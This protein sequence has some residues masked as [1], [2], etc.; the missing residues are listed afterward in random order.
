MSTDGLTIK[1]RIALLKQSSPSPNNKNEISPANV[2]PKSTGFALQT[3][4]IEERSKSVSY[5]DTDAI[6]GRVVALKL[7]S[8]PVSSSENQGDKSSGKK[9]IADRI[10]ALQHKPL[11]DSNQS[12][13]VPKKLSVNFN[14]EIISNDV[15]GNESNLPSPP[16][17]KLNIDRS[18]F[19]KALNVGGFNPF[20]PRPV[21]SKVSDDSSPSKVVHFDSSSNTNNGEMKHVIRFLSTL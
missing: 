8:T 14:N 9:S 2:R 12:P 3:S 17:R 7:Q 1:E 10:A 15:E 16:L 11:E 5:V 19:A 4:H 6:A 20:A 21:T 13:S 18:N